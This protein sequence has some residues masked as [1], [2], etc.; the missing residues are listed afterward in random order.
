[1]KPTASVDGSRLWR[2]LVVSG[3]LA[4]VASPVLAQTTAPDKKGTVERIKVR[5]AALDG[6]LEGDSPDR[7]VFIYLPPGYATN[8]NQRYPV[9]YLLHGYGLTAER[10]MPFTGLAE[11][12]DKLIAGGAIKEMIFV[13]P[14][15]Y[16]KHGGSMYS[17]SATIGDWE[18]YIAEDL[19]GYVDK[20]YRTIP[21]RESRGLAGH[22]MGGYGTF[23]IGM[24][25]PDVFSALYPMSACCLIDNNIAGGGRGG[26]GGAR[27]APGAA[28][29][30]ANPAAPSA[31]APPAQPA[32]AAPAA[33]GTAPAAAPG[34]ARAGAP[35]Q[36][37]GA[38]GDGARG[39]GPGRGAGRGGGF[40][41]VQFA[42]AAAWA[43]NPK[44]PPDF[45]DLP[46]VDGVP[47]PLIVAKFAANSP[48]MMLSQYV[49]N[50]KKY[51][52]I[53]IDVGNQDGLAASNHQIEELMT[54]L[55]V[56]H[57]FET[58]EGDHSNR[59][60]QRFETSVLPFFSSNLSFA[61]PKR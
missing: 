60:P 22:S 25:R 53:K 32:A 56:A 4:A 2:V 8:R 11:T 14:D 34:G 39:A 50:L 26:R 27:G 61:V 19:V 35:Q 52:A 28:G 24:K 1:M 51:K 7:D 3:V 43:P 9:V 21:N 57:V 47:Q 42:L 36:A 13:S 49:T 18:T 20:N 46:T 30:A 10:W 31:G 17:A 23:R 15:A 41:N 29:A 48:F 33:P 44:N 54:D 55:G 40:G 5:G 59:V 38:R 58:Y 37:A 12:A 45:F 6:N 16:T